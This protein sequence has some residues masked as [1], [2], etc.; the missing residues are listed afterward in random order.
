MTPIDAGS[1][2]ARAGGRIVCR[3]VYRFLIIFVL[4]VLSW[5]AFVAIVVVLL[6]AVCAVVRLVTQK[7][8]VCELFSG[9]L[10]SS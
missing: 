4:S 5:V 7:R 9:L 3:L 1:E 2:A 8:E 6:N 10:G